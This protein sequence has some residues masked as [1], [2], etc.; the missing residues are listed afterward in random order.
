MAPYQQAKEYQRDFKK[1]AKRNLNTILAAVNIK[2]F[3]AWLMGTAWKKPH[4]HSV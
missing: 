2:H 1:K 4:T 3:H